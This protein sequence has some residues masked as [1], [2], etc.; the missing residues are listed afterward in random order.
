MFLFSSG[1][2]RSRSV[3]WSDARSGHYADRVWRIGLARVDAFCVLT[4]MPIW[5]GDPVFRLRVSPSSFP[6]NH[7]RMILAPVVPGYLRCEHHSEP[8]R[9]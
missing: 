3:Y 5:R 7:N 9:P 1:C 8:E 4:G 2:R 6:A